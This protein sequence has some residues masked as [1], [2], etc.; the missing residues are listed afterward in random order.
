MRHRR[1]QAPGIAVH[2][3]ARV[4]SDAGAGEIFVSQTVKDLVAGTA[5]EFLGWGSHPLKGVPGEWRPYSV[6]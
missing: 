4:A 6:I 1:R 5:I 2:I 3:G